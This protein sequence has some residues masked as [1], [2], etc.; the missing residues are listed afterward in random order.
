MREKG[1][2][3]LAEV[4]E[5]IKNSPAS[6]ASAERGFAAVDRTVPH[7]RRSLA[8]RT[9]AMQVEYSSYLYA[10]PKK[11]KQKNLFDED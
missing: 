6:E 7:S 8:P 10:T 5:T 2:N 3:L 9:V 11:D 1:L 4:V